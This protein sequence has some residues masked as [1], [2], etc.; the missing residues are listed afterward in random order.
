MFLPVIPEPGA[1]LE[2]AFRAA[3]AASGPEHATRQA[4]LA[5]DDLAPAAWVIAIG[6]GAHAMASGAVA[7][8]HQRGVRIGGGIV[9][10]H[11]E[12]PDARHGLPAVSGDHPVPA[13]QSSI[14]ADRLGVLAE[15]VPADADAVVLVSGGATSLV[16]SPIAGLPDADLRGAFSALLAS[17]AD[18]EVMNALRK[19]L[20]RFGG[21]RLALAL[22]ARRIHCLI[23]SDVPGNDPSAI[24]S[25]PCAPDPSPA[26]HARAR[27]IEAGAWASLPPAARRVI[28]DMASGRLPDLPSVDDARFATT[29]VRVIL[30]RTHAERGAADEARR[31]GCVVEVV[32]P[33]LSGEAAIAGRRFGVALAERARTTPPTC[34]IWSGETTVTLG[35]SAGHGGRCQEFALACAQVLHERAATGITVLAA[36][37]DGRDGPTEVAGA[38]VDATTWARVLDA[39]VDPVIALRDHASYD[40]LQAAGALLRTGPTG[41]NVNDLVLALV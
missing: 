33:A 3:V 1:V 32:E 23:A 12:D 13:A 4:V 19:R 10:A 14:A 16:A 8:L 18:I 28:D 39:G 24:A 15:A 41:T 20:L 21:G 25:G 26:S 37:T 22:R 2:R 17:G 29:S 34:I 6:K 7:A 40:A 35:S 27:A 38:I 36:G 11:A 5:T 30:D 31:S 9:V